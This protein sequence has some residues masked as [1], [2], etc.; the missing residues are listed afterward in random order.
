MHCV[1]LPYA[2]LTVSAHERESRLRL[3]SETILR[4]RLETI[5]H[6]VQYTTLPC[7]IAGTALEEGMYLPLSDPVEAWHFDLRTPPED[8]ER[9]ALDLSFTARGRFNA[10]LFWF[11]LHLIDGIE[12]STGPEA[13]AHGEIPSR[14]H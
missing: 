12:F 9:K 3:R 6:T 2:V 10:V 13:V 1:I 4:L 7:C 8:S 14:F 11:K 5:G